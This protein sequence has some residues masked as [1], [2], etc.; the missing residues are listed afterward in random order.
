MTTETPTAEP[1]DA[2]EQRLVATLTAEAATVVEP[3]DG[4]DRIRG[5]VVHR[6]RARRATWLAAA[7]AMVLI[8]GTVGVL[9]RSS[10][11]DSAPYVGTES[12]GGMPLLGFADGG[13]RL[14]QYAPGM[15]YL[16][17]ASGDRPATDGRY[18]QLINLG[19]DL[20]PGSFTWSGEETVSL[21]GRQVRIGTQTTSDGIGNESTSRAVWWDGGH[22]WRVTVTTGYSGDGPTRDDL[23]AAA[24]AVVQVSPDAW[25]R[26]ETGGPDPV[27]PF[28][29]PRL[30]LD[31]DAG[32]SQ[33][34]AMSGNSV[35]SW[36]TIDDATLPDVALLALPG[37]AMQ[38]RL[39]QGTGLVQVRGVRGSFTTGYGGPRAVLVWVEDGQGYEISADAGASVDQLTRIADLLVEPS[40]QT[41]EALVFPGEPR[42]FPEA[43]YFR[44]DPIDG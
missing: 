28:D 42:D 25:E 4:L 35:T 11:T 9:L 39:E 10:S 43:A 27:R 37:G 17:I 1:F 14:F 12:T 16:V 34:I 19:A 26:G 20:G 3:A 44:V 15:S 29:E 40:S 33:V 13:G 6:R 7:A 5:R 38:D 21:D 36:L 41:W 8:A 18:L 30:V 22:G 23:L 31:A 32:G 24:A 2:F